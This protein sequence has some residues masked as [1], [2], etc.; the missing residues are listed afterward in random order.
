[1]NIAIDYDGTY[2]R[3]PEQFN[4]LRESFQKIG[5]RVFIVTAR[6]E[7]LMPIHEDLSKFDDVIYTCNKAKAGMIDADIFIDDNPVTLCCDMVFDNQDSQDKGSFVEAYPSSDLYQV[8]EDE[9]YNWHWKDKYF[10]SEKR[11]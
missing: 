9:S 2:S 4:L 8:Y 10:V 7:E 5:A 1:M 6:C 11:K 3:F